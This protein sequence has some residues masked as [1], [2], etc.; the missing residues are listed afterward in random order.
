MTLCKGFPFEDKYGHFVIITNVIDELNGLRRQ[1]PVNYASGF[2]K[3]IWNKCQWTIANNISNSRKNVSFSFLMP[4]FL[5]LKAISLGNIS[6]KNTNGV[7]IVVCVLHNIGVALHPCRFS[8]IAIAIAQEE[9]DFTEDTYM[10]EDDQS[11]PVS[12]QMRR[13]FVTNNF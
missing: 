4:I 5:F 2:H 6:L 1:V 8:K 10:Y 7:I 3:F 9:L 13:T 11:V 12:E